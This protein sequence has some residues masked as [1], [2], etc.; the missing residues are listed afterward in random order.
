M[1]YDRLIALGFFPSYANPTIG[2][3]SIQE[4]KKE[5]DYYDIH[6]PFTHNYLAEGISH[7][8]SGKT[9]GFIIKLFLLSMFFPGNRIL[10]GRKSRVDVEQATLPDLF[11]IFPENSYKYKPG[12]GIIEFPNGSQILIYGLDVMQGGTSQDIKKS[13]QKI[14]SLNLGG[15]FIDQLEEIDYSIIEA[16][17]GRLRKDVPLQQMNF[18]GNPA[19]YW[20]YDY[21]K[22]NPRPNTK[23]IETGMLDNKAN[24]KPEY[25]ADQMSKPKIYVDKYVYGIWSPDTLVE[26]TVFNHEHISLVQSTIAD[27]IRSFDGINIYTSPQKH[28][29]HIGVDPS[30]G[31]EDP[32]HICVVDKETGEEVANFSGYV[33]T[34][35]IV[36]KTFQLATMYSLKS[37]P[38]VIPEVTGVG[39][40]FVEEMKKIYNN[41]YIREVFNHR[42]NKKTQKIGFYTNFSTKTQLIEH[43]RNLFD[44]KFPKIRD[45]KTLDE[46]R[47]FI[48]TD[49][50]AQKGAGAQRGYH[51]D[52][53]MGKLLAYWNVE[54]VY[55]RESDR[56][57]ELGNNFNLYSETFN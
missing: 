30:I 5:E 57:N 22:V 48:Y 10:L 27:P 43:M 8:N 37:E 47:T 13:I 4:E 33:P 3:I 29:Y 51:D 55:I 28:D 49:E 56:E 50:A 1:F 14:K 42:E 21:F 19:N 40:A 23:L 34:N 39:Q 31:S 32:C 2:I 38:L 52:R 54:Y 16:L 12:P 25:L 20:A 6:V 36:Q 18:T 41:I 17:T 15:V 45:A 44:K 46:I 53:V 24:L 35:V 9:T 7:H 26:G 11:D